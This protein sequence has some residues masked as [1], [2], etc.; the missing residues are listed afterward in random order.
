MASSY[1]SWASKLSPMP[2]EELRHAAVERVGGGEG[3][4]RGAGVVVLLAAD[5]V[6]GDQELGVEDGA[7]GVGRLGAVGELRQVA[8]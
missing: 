2:E 1:F 7:L 4:P 5:E 6:L 8:P 3:P